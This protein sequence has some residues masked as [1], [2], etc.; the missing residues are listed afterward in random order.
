MNEPI[1][2][3]STVNLALV[4]GANLPSDAMKLEPAS[5]KSPHILEDAPVEYRLYKRRFAGCVGLVSLAP[6]NLET[7]F[8]TKTSRY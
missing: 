4:D 6:I 1:K 5:I 8:N 2:S 7:P 3:S